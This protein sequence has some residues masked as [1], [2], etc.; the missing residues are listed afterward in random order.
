[1]KEKDTQ[2]FF[3]LYNVIFSQILRLFKFLKIS[4]VKYRHSH[5]KRKDSL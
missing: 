2:F 3:S 4:Y 1:M 5:N